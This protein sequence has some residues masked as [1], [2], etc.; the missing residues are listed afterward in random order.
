[1]S[2]SERIEESLK[3]LYGIVE[4]FVNSNELGLDAEAR[5]RNLES[6]GMVVDGVQLMAE[7]LEHMDPIILRGLTES[8]VNA[9]MSNMS[10]DQGDLDTLMGVFSNLK[11]G[12]TSW[13]LEEMPEVKPEPKPEEKGED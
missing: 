10:Y 11:G 1:M 8:F 7:G 3:E 6:M 5:K 12:S 4:A 9:L 2:I 13:A